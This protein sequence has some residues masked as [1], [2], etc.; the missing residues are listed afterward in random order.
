MD[1]SVYCNTVKRYDSCVEETR[2]SQLNEK[3]DSQTISM[4][5]TIADLFE[6]YYDK[7]VRYIYIRISDQAEAEDLAGEVFLKA[8]QSMGSYRGSV[9]QLRFWIFKIA[10]NIVIDHYRKMGKRKTINLDDVEISDNSNVEEVA[11]RML[12]VGELMKAMNQLTEAQR[13]VIGLRF[14]A[15]LS[16][17]ETARMMGKS[18]GAVREMQ[19]DALQKLRKLM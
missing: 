7:V 13:E 4:E 16:S 11:E 2:R 19:C 12:Q 6:D 15:G 10:R 5:S 14:F 9:T 8:L 17:E 1:S 3:I 18:S